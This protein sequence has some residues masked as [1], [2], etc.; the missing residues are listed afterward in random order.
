VLD[1]G[2]NG[3]LIRKCG[4]MTVVLAGGRVRAGDPIKVKLPDPPFMSLE[5]V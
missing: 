3:E 1:K 4:I 2:P 5:R